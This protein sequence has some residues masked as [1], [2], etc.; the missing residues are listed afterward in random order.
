MYPPPYTTYGMQKLMGEYFCQGANQQYGL[1]YSIVRPFNAVGVGECDSH[2]GET[3]VLPDLVYKAL[4]AKNN[5]LE[6]YGNGEQIRHYTHARDVAEGIKL[7]MEKGGTRP[8]NISTDVST[9]VRELARLVWN[10]IHGVDPNFKYKEGFPCDVQKRI[11][12]TELA[13]SLGFE[14]KITLEQSIDEVINWM[15]DKV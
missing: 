3:H 11:P 12:C 13:K 8:Y 10:K 5:S 1:P 6:I 14:A 15:K 7:V 9:S 2:K 4:T